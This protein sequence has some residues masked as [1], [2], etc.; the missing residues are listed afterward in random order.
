MAGQVIDRKRV[1]V[2]PQA[3]CTGKGPKSLA[4]INRRRGVDMAAVGIQ[5]RRGV[6]TPVCREV[7][8]VGKI[9]QRCD[10]MVTWGWKR[11]A[12][13]LS[14]QG[15]FVER[16][17][18]KGRSSSLVIEGHRHD[19]IERQE[20]E[21]LS[22]QEGQEGRHARTGHA[23]PRRARAKPGQARLGRFR[24][25]RRKGRCMCNPINYFINIYISVYISVYTNIYTIYTNI[26]I[27]TYF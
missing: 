4:M 2:A 1:Q 24:R 26:H 12:A 11:S 22:A 16:R 14:R 8:V 5:L 18:G 21:I 6:G 20:V 9:V 10:S 23:K 27:N 15:R 19:F 3:R 17:D 25:G 13:R 7:V